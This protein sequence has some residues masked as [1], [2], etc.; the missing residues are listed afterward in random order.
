MIIAMIACLEPP[1]YAT[2]HKNEGEQQPELDVRC[3]CVQCTWH[4]LCTYTGVQV[5]TS[6]L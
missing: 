1:R 6:S 3:S 4:Q 5:C 2:E